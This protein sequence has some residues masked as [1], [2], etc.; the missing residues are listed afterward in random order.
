MDAA[1]RRLTPAV[2]AVLS[3]LSIALVFAVAGGIVP[4]GTLPA[5]SGDLLA[6]IPHINAALSCIALVTIL[7]GIRA[8]RVGD[9]ARHRALMF[10]SFGVFLVFLA[11]YLYRVAIAGPTEF[12]GPALVRTYVYYPILVVHVSLAVLCIPLL[13]HTLLLAATYPTRELSETIH[14]RLGRIAA[15]LWLL[16]FALGLAVYLLVYLAPA[17]VW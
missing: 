1:Y 8:I 17:L 16:S 2:T 11:G 3:S 14:P 15:P 12:Q 10:A 5:V 13:Y 7:L 6:A 4:S 9:I